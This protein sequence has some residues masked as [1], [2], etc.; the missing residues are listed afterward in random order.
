MATVNE[1][2]PGIVVDGQYYL[3]G[4]A[5]MP[6]DIVRRLNANEWML[7]AVQIH[8]IAVQSMAAAGHGVICGYGRSGQ[9]LARFLEQEN[10]AVIALDVDP[11]RIR[12]AA[13]GL[14]AEVQQAQVRVEAHGRPVVRTAGGGP[15][16]HG[17]LAVEGFLVHDGAA[18]LEVDALGPV[19]LGKGLGGDQFS[20]DAIQ[21]VVEAA[22]GRLHDHLARPAFDGEVGQH[23]LR[24][25]V[26]IPV[27]VGHHLVVPLQAAGGGV[28]AEVALRRRVPTNGHRLVGHPHV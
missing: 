26:V 14:A 5:S 18:G 15:Q 13:A 11:E 24:D 19:D 7:R 10:V 4:P 25:G 27:I 16:C 3:M 8:N 21:H 17:V 6:G 28:D 1:T 12:E 9:N 20:G 23:Q 2:L 22:L